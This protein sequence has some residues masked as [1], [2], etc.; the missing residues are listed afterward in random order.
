L[1]EHVQDVMAENCHEQPGL[2]GSE[3]VAT[4][5]VPSQS[6]LPFFDPILNVTSSIVYL[7]YLP[8]RELGVGIGRQCDYKLSV[9]GTPSFPGVSH[10]NP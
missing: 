3:S 6:V 7:D 10:E 5:L 1:A 2:I 8:S 9:D 4:G